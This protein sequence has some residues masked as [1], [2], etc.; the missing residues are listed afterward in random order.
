MTR[1]D[2]A[3]Y[4]T[5]HQPPAEWYDEWRDPMKTCTECTIIPERTPVA[6]PT[7]VLCP[8]HA[9]ADELARALKTLVMFC[10]ED[11]GFNDPSDTSPYA[12]LK[13]AEETLRRIGGAP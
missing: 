13:I 11:S 8:K 6:N 1:A 10:Q 9:A 12:A 4:R 3:E 7:V 5:K 2:W